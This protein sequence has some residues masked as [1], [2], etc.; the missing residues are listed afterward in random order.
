MNQSQLNVFAET[1]LDHTV[2]LTI[3]WDLERVYSSLLRTPFN[4]GPTCEG[5]GQ[6]RASTV[7]QWNPLC[8]HL[9]FGP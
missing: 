4:R 2:K 8:L 9:E 6:P 3:V 5:F 1:N 7:N